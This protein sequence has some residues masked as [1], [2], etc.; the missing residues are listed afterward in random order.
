MSDEMR[1]VTLRGTPLEIAQA[2]Y[3]A[4]KRTGDGAAVIGRP[5]G[6]DWESTM[7]DGTWD[8]VAPITA[9]YDSTGGQ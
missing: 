6:D 5:N 2:L 7:I 9:L 3:D 1:T 4:L 8:L